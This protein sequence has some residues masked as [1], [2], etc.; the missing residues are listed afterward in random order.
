MTITTTIK[1]LLIVLVVA[2][3]THMVYVGHGNSVELYL[4]SIF[5]II[6]GFIMLFVRRK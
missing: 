6:A 4:A 2:V 5:F 3:W 1:M